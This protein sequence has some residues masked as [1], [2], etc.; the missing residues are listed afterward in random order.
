MRKCNQQTK[1]V[2]EFVPL[3]I[4]NLEKPTTHSYIAKQQSSYLRKLKENIAPN[5]AILLLDFAENFAFTVQDE[6]Q[7]YH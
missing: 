6:I 1:P 2:Q 5:K 7:S 3:V 4:N